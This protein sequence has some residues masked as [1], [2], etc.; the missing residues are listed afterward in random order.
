MS[1]GAFLFPAAVLA[2]VGI[3]IAAM[4]VI[5]ARAF[6]VPGSELIEEVAD[7]LP[8]VNCGA[9]GYP[10]CMGYA[11]AIV[12]EDAPRDRCVPGGV[13]LVPKIEAALGEAAAVAVD[14]AA[15]T[16]DLAADHEWPP[17]HELPVPRVAAVACAGGDLVEMRYRYVGLGT[18]SAAT[19]VGG[20][21]KACW[22]GCQG[23]GDCVEVCPFDAL[24]IRSGVA[25]VDPDKCTGCSLCVPS[26]PK[27]LISMVPVSAGVVLQCSNTL[28]AKQV[29]TVCSVGCIA[30]ARCVK[31]CPTD[32]VTMHDNLPSIDYG[33]CVGNRECVKVC[34]VDCLA[35]GVDGAF[36]Q[37]V[38]REAGREWRP[39]GG[40]SDES[41]PAEVGAGAD[42]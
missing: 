6:H 36:R 34:P 9:C 22:A 15:G 14:V 2:G 10:G 26:C 32:A 20:G 29:S 30:C 21:F 3:A 31:A 39:S 27:K 38:L 23:L 18:C 41:E 12:K 40:A 17:R 28:R 24:S 42:A 7:I 11:D 5:A 19:Q 13:D 37:A 8:G 1:A 35:P 16:A 25:V 4:L 33:T